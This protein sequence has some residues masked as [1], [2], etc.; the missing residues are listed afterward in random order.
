LTLRTFTLRVEQQLSHEL[1][2]QPETTTGVAHPPQL[3][4][5]NKPA[6]AEVAAMSNAAVAITNPRTII[7]SLS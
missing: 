4:R 6:S 3:L 7:I 5:E 2:P 1:L